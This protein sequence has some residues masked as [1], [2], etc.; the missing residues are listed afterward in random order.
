MQFSKKD[1]FTVP[2]ILTY[3]RLICVPI[4]I[5]VMIAYC[6]DKTATQYLWAAFGLFVFASATDIADGYI[7]RRFNL[8]SDIGKVLDPVADKLLQG[9]AILM[10]G[11]AGNVHWA[12]VAIIVAKEIFIGVTSKYFM[13]ASKRQVEQMAN[14]W[15]KYAALTVFI[16]LF[17]AFLV[18]FHKVIE[19]G[20][21]VIFCIGSVLAIAA[22]TQYTVIYCKQLAQVRKSGILEVLDKNGE[23]L[24]GRNIAVVRAEYGLKDYH[25]KSVMVDVVA[26][27]QENADRASSDVATEENNDVKDA[28]KDAEDAMKDAE[29]A[30]KDVEDA[31]KDVE[32]AKKEDGENK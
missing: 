32:D 23:P 26:K 31:M 6:I 24:D 2:N 4:F 21:L 22:A 17:F 15:G 3:I 20:D 8:I 9:F 30:M 19:I 28:M 27:E 29:D 5:G 14:K 13:R 1:L 10:L 25:N 11:I 16:G 18:P 12:F 7:A